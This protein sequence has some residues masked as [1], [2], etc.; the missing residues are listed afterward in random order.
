VLKEPEKRV[1]EKVVI[2]VVDVS[3]GDDK[4]Q[5]QLL[6]RKLYFEASVMLGGHTPVA[7]AHGAGDPGQ[8]YILADSAEGGYNPTAAP[9]QLDSVVFD[10]VV[11]GASI[12][13][14]DKAPLGKKFLAEIVEIGISL[15]INGKVGHGCNL[16]YPPIV[17]NRT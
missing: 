13:D 10:A 12:A 3:G 4:T 2:F 7:F 17:V 15:I 9:V 1:A 5:I 6:P 16:A 8:L 11:N 14:K